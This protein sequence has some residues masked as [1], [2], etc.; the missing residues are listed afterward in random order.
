MCV[1]YTL[2]ADAGFIQYLYGFVRYFCVVSPPQIH[3]YVSVNRTLTTLSVSH[4]IDLDR[5]HDTFIVVAEISCPKDF[6]AMADGVCV[7]FSY[8]RA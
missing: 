6:A 4:N 8:C 1:S 5:K 2:H 7:S 3:C